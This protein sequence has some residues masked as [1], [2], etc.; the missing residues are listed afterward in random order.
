MEN[1]KIKEEIDILLETGSVSK[2]KK[3]IH[4]LMK[5]NPKEPELKRF[6]ATVYYQNNEILRAFDLMKQYL[7]TGCGSS[8]DYA[9]TARLCVLLKNNKQ[10]TY[11]TKVKD[12]DCREY[13]FY[14]AL[15]HYV[16]QEYE[17]A[18]NLFRTLRKENRRDFEIN[19]YVTLSQY[20]LN[21]RSSE[22]LK[23][24][25][26]NAKIKIDSELQIIWIDYLFRNKKFNEC[27]VKC[28]EVKGAPADIKA[29]DYATFV[30]QKIKNL[31]GEKQEVKDPIA[32]L[33]NSKY[34]KIPVS[35]RTLD[36]ALNRLDEK[37]G[38]HEVKRSIYDLVSQIQ[39]NKEREASGLSIESK[40]RYNFIFMGN[41]GTGKTM[42]ARLIGDILYHLDILESGHTVEVDRSMLI[43]NVI[44]GTEINT[45]EALEAA[46]DGVLFVDEAY[47]FAGSGNDFGPI[48]IDTIMKY[49]EDHRGSITVIFAGYEEEM[50][51]EFLKI[52]PGIYSRVPYHIN[53][54]DYN[55]KEMLEIAKFICE[56][57]DFQMSKDGEAGFLE[58]V[59][60]KMV[61]SNFSNARDAELLISEA[62]KVLAK[63]Y[64]EKKNKGLQIKAEDKYLLT[65]KCFGIDVSLSPEERIKRSQ[66]QLENLIG[67][68]NVKNQVRSMI[69]RKKMQQLTKVK[70]FE[71][72]SFHMRFVGNP[73]TGK[74]TVA[75]I[76]ADIYR[77]LGILKT[78]KV[79]EV[80]PS[81]FIGQYNGQTVPKTRA[82]IES[83]YGGLIFID[84]AYGFANSNNT[85]ANEALEE[86]L[87]QMEN[88]RDKLV[89]VFAGYK[90]D[91][92]RLLKMND[93]LA[94][95]V[96]IEIEFDDYSELELFE[97]FKLMFKTNGLKLSE[98]AELKA[99]EKI[100]AISN[101]RSSKFG[102]GRE[103]RN[104]YEFTLQQ[105]MNR[106]INQ[107]I[108]NEVELITITSEDFD[109]SW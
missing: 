103:M 37:I 18:L 55:E 104:F 27:Q 64:V 19:K 7:N 48:A 61:T 41:P 68:N 60:S 40:E 39:F 80:T 62:Q 76:I 13:T 102:N 70:A 92:S 81:D 36:E 71:E 94:S 66:A 96:P 5:D 91:I 83:A 95:R 93:G 65:S 69:N 49:M 77:E 11:I 24:L 47:S 25:K 42:I 17:K 44:G 38:L 109:N 30:D 67:L 79:L 58:K 105:H 6:G 22:N 75:R 28:M 100:K 88:N 4:G 14:I 84:E 72:G 31:S 10:D 12:K 57:N 98:E 56:K 1:T 97:I 99:I 52:N 2:A 89:F 33:N 15:V 45:K 21:F 50:T 87:V 86:I 101:K 32:K 59:S 9:Y 23:N 26:R 29:S 107:G 35:T 3:Y 73:G 16:N 43:S 34:Q 106:C 85:F 74:T 78:N 46:N 82:L 108:E 90:D 63:L 20:K 51:E 54:E 53:F 8:D